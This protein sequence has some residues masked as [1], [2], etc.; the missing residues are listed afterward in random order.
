MKVRE[1]VKLLLKQ[2]QCA[3]ILISDGI[4]EMSIDGIKKIDGFVCIY[5]EDELDDDD[6]DL[7]RLEDLLDEE[8]EEDDE[9]FNTR[10]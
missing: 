10:H 3:T 7:A 2:D 9:I 4:E 6:E 5:G 1:L 8:E